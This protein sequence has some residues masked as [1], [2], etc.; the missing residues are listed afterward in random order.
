[1][2]H[3]ALSVADAV[4]A[5]GDFASC[6]DIGHFI[7]K[8]EGGAV[9]SLALKLLRPSTLLSLSSSLWQVHY[10]NAGRAVTHVAGPSAIRL[11][12]VDYPTP[13]RGHCL[14]VGGWIQGALEMGRRRSIKVAKVACRCDGAPSCDLTVSWE[15]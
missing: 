14:T 4:G 2:F 10:K 7:S 9:R 11:S 3:E 15:E 13:H 8:H 1:M 5:K 12:I 6:W